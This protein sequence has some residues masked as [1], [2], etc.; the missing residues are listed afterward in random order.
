MGGSDNEEVCSA[1]AS[2]FLETDRFFFS[3]F[4]GKQIDVQRDK[5]KHTTVKFADEQCG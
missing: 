4:F 2:C 3:F 5:E 1:T